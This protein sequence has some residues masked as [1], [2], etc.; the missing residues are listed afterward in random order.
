MQVMD[1]LEG[2]GHQRLPWEGDQLTAVA[3]MR[4]GAFGQI[5]LQQLQRRPE[6]RPS[7]EAVCRAA[8]C[9]GARAEGAAT[10]HSAGPPL[11][12][13]KPHMRCKRPVCRTQ[14]A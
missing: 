12:R 6:E 13:R 4:L 14:D 9:E 2:R 5:L 11:L 1:A 8:D 7:M 10:G 3:A